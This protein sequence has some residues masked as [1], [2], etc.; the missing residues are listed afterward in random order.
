M[1]DQCDSAPIDGNIPCDGVDECVEEIGA[2]SK[3]HGRRANHCESFARC[4]ALQRPVSISIEEDVF[5]AARA[6]KCDDE[7]ERPYS[8]WHELPHWKIGSEH[9]VDAPHIAS[10][11]KRA[12]TTFGARELDVEI[13]D[14]LWKVGEQGC[15]ASAIDRLCQQR[16][17]RQQ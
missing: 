2:D 4:S 12:F 7:R 5:I 9:A 16:A 3:R 6:V 11:R 8:F 1:P 13:F 15:R 14:N 10:T 17:S